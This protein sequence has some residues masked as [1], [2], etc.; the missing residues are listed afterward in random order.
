M[1]GTV[2]PL[3]LLEELLELFALFELLLMLLVVVFDCVLAVVVVPLG[4]VVVVEFVAVVVVVV[5]SVVVDSEL[6]TKLTLL[7]ALASPERAAGGPR[8]LERS[9][10]ILLNTARERFAAST[11]SRLAWVCVTVMFMTM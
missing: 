7:G 1:S 6:S 11:A 4:V 10:E 2:G 5:V 8:T 3:V 9:R